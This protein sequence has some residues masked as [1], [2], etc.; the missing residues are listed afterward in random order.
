MHDPFQTYATFGQHMG[1][2]PFGIPTPIGPQYGQLQNPAFGAALNPLLGLSQL[3]GLGQL[4]QTGGI[5]Q[6]GQLYG[7]SLY[8][9]NPGLYGQTQAM[10]NPLVASLLS[11]P[12]IA[13]SL[14]SNP[15]VAASLHAQQ[16]F[17]GLQQQPFAGIQQQPFAGM[18]Q[19]PFAGIHSQFGQPFGQI[20]YPLA[21][22]SW[23][24]QGG[25]FGQR[26]FQSF[27]PWG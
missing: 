16:P 23:I 26:P 2:S 17:G 14:L 1:S 3:A 19:Q 27:S 13:A 5:P 24:G 25:Q 7:Q 12:L 22:Q 9:Q 10:M 4:G 15:L 21:P 8:G 18:Q 11:N 6:I 20:G